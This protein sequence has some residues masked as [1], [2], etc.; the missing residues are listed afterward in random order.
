L[1][2]VPSGAERVLVDLAR[3]DLLDATGLG[4][5]AG[6]RARLAPAGGRLVLSCPD[7]LRARLAAAGLEGAFEV[8]GSI[9]AV[10]AGCPCGE[11]RP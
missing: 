3:V 11:A 1:A 2:Q 5:L 8:V 9:D 6:L 7:A 10:V 4:L